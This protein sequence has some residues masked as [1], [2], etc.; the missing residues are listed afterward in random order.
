M[1]A[2]KRFVH[3]LISFICR[4]LPIKNRVLFFSIRSDGKLLDNMQAVYDALDAQK[5]VFAKMYP[6]STKQRP[7]IQYYLL[8]S[9]VIVTDDYISY[10]RYTKLRKEQ[11]LFQIW[12]ACGAFKKFG[13]DADTVLDEREERASHSQYS[14]VA[15]TSEKCRK[16][17]AGAM[18]ICEDICLPIGLPRTDLLFKDADKLKESVYEKHPELR[19]KRIYLFAPTFR[20]KD[21]VKVDYDPAIDWDKLSKS[22]ADDEVF[23]IRR[24][25]VMKYDLINKEYSNITDLSQDS[26]LALTAAAQVLITDYSSV[27]YDACL[28]DVPTVFYCPDYKEYTRGFYLNFPDDLPGEMV[29]EPEKLLA[30]IRNAKENL[31]VQRIE[32]FR[33]EQISACDGHAAERAAQVIKDWLK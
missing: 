30:A 32:K 24:H 11:K 16:F 20:E 23:V 6:H 2:L 8:T 15:V 19:G 21:G 4:L 22:L 17:Y 18:G 12:H 10:L 31:P 7:K 28:L 13:L 29:A 9:K 5:V 27:M 1:K 25:P 3:H 14:A 33:N 26:T